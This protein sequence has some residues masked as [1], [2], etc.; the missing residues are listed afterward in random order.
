[1]FG[2]KKEGEQ[3]KPKFGGS[4]TL[5]LTVIMITAFLT[6]GCSV[7]GGGGGGDDTSNTTTTGT[8]PD[9]NVSANQLLFGGIVV[10][11]FTDRTLTIQNK[12]SLSLNIGRIAQADP[13]A[14]PFSIVTDDCSLKTLASQRT[15][16]VVVRFEPTTQTLV[17][18]FEDTFDI[19]SNDPDEN[20]VT[21]IVSGKGTGLNVSINQV[22]TNCPN[23]IPTVT[24]YITVADE[25]GDPLVPPLAKGQFVLSENGTQIAPGDITFDDTVTSPKSIALV[26]DISYSMG[27]DA[28]NEMQAAAENFI[29]SPNF[30]PGDEAEIIR[31]AKSI[32]LATFTTFTSNKVVL[33]DAIQADLPPNNDDFRKFTAMYDAVEQAVTDT[34]AQGPGRRQAVV[35]IADGRDNASAADLNELIDQ[36]LEEGV[37]VFTI[38]L[39]DVNAEIMQQLA[40]ETG[41]QYYFALDET[42]LQD[43]YDQISAIISSQY[44]LEFD[45]ASSCND[46]ISLDVVVTDGGLQGEDSRDV[47]LN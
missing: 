10:N 43:I 1:M 36:A 17:D 41:G 26:L 24:L 42:K 29:N 37:P 46:I 44:T 35:V 45:S 7:G 22:S 33:I 34:A 15:C 11:N 18:P 20:P 40:D 8:P 30:E 9:I 25:D 38:G 31:F 4:R 13:L 19:P 6:G 14:L 47:T 21:V 5:F 39:G 2:R 27:D 16:T 28:I 3:M 23:P 12:G 32:E